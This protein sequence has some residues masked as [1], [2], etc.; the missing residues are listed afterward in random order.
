MPHIYDVCFKVSLEAT[1]NEGAFKEVS[2]D[3]D[4]L[5]SHLEEELT[6]MAMETWR[7]RS[8]EEKAVWRKI[9]KELE[10]FFTNQN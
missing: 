1:N 5:A 7:R 4:H 9:A 3:L 6:R 10:S 8:V 2:F